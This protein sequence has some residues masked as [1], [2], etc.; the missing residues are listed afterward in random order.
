VDLDEVAD[1]LYAVLPE[2]FVAVRGQRQDDARAAGDRTLAREIGGL[3][4]P[5]AA[6]W[7]CN[8]LVRE[9]RA[10]QLVLLLREPPVGERHLPEQ[11]DD[12]GDVAEDDRLIVGERPAELPEQRLQVWKRA[13]LLET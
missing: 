8:L 10:E 12:D 4:K 2:E 13:L 1:E 9:Q 3:P 5:T 7:V 6:A 11:H